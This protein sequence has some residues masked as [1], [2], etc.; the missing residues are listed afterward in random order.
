MQIIA[1]QTTGRHLKNILIVGPFSKSEYL[2]QQIKLYVPAHL[3][4]TIVRPADS[5][6]SVVKGLVTAGISRYDYR[7]GIAQ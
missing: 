7:M 2:L 6:I 5:E 3:Q 4:A 1:I